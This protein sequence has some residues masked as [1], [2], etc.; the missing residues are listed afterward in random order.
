M[1]VYLYLMPIKPIAGD[2]SVTSQIL[3]RP[4]KLRSVPVPKVSVNIKSEGTH[5]LWKQHRTQ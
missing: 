4:E 3:Q 2:V 1:M 5:F